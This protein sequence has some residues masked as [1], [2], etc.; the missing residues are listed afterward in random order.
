[1]GNDLDGF[2]KVKILDAPCG[3]GKTS[4]AIQ[5]MNE[6]IDENTKVFYVTPYLDEV[7]RIK[8]SCPKMDF[9]DPPKKFEVVDDFKSQKS[10]SAGLL[11]LVLRGENI[12]TTHALLGKVSERVIEALRAQHYI[13]ILDE[14]FTV[15]EELA[16]KTTVGTTIADKR[17]EKFRTWEIIEHLKADGVVEKMED[18]TGL[19]TW[20]DERAYETRADIRAFQEISSLIKRELL[21]EINDKIIFWTFPIELFR[22]IFVESFIL[23]FQFD[24]QLQKSYYDFF[25]LQYEYYHPVLDKSTGKYNLVKTENRDYEI[26]WIKKIRERIVINEDEKL[27]RIGDYW[28][29]INGNLR[30]YNLSKSWYE[31]NADGKSNIITNSLR[32]SLDNF[33][34]NQAHDK[35]SSKRMWTTFKNFKK[36]FRGSRAGERNFLSIGTRATNM[37]GHKTVLAYLINRFHNPDILQFFSARDIRV[38]VDEYALSDIIQWMFR[39]NLRIEREQ[40]IDVF[41]E[42]KT[43][44]N[45]DRVAVMERIK[46]EPEIV[47]IYI[48]SYRMRKILK[49]YF[50]FDER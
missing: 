21:Y 8:L 1:M 5:Y 15:V 14:V 49:D 30:D 9:K 24:A 18:A 11:E 19:L 27:N 36:Y 31:N 39:S 17:E 47:E 46:V 40:E 42:W 3:A 28:Y 10:K 33:F 2:K 23:T 45:G 50:W 35:R 41:R 37:Y 43:E 29:D 44:E 16:Q 12:C 4:Y 6:E 48:P 34:N 22:D 25:G 20:N 26:E 13:L 38:P 32:K 7:N